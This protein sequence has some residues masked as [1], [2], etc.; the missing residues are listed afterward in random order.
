MDHGEVLLQQRLAADHVDGGVE[1]LRQRLG[2][3]LQLVRP[4]IGGRDVD[5][6]AGQSLGIGQ[7]LDPLGVNPIGRDQ[8]GLGRRLRGIAVKGIA[9]QQ[10]TQRFHRRGGLGQARGDA[11]S[12]R[13]Q[14]L[15]R[16]RQRK[17]FARAFCGRA[18]ARQR[19]ARRAIGLRHHQHLPQRAGEAINGDPVLHLIRLA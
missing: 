19:K 6:I 18:V 1:F 16:S 15:C 2:C 3:G 13:R 4:H 5:Q 8:P 7:N 9:S 11:I 17:P 12:S 10:P 14:S